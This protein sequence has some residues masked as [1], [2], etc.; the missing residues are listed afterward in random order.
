MKAYVIQYFI[1]ALSLPK[2][3]SAVPFDPFT[4]SSLWTNKKEAEEPTLC[5]GFSASFL[6]IWL[7]G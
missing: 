5:F 1:K 3:R 6:S 7:I 4:P 2:P